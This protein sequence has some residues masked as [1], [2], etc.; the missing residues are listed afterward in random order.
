[1]FSV[2]E[3]MILATVMVM[4]AT[5]MVMLAT[6]MVMLA[7]VMVMVRMGGKWSSWAGDPACRKVAQGRR[8]SSS[9]TPLQYRAQ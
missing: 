8:K 5:L 3:L 4:L 1:M 9:R 7:T 2:R 6:V